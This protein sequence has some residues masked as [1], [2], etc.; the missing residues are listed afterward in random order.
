MKKVLTI[1]GFDP[2]GG[3]GIA[4][5]LKTFQ[6]RGVYGMGVATAVTAQN[7]A[8]YQ[9]TFPIAPRF[10]GLQIDSIMDDIG[11]D[12]WKTGMLVNAHII[13]TVAQKIKHYT[14]KKVIVDPVIVSKTGRRL[15]TKD[16]QSILAKYLLPLT[17]IITPNIDEAKAMTGI[18]IQNVA[19]IKKAAIMLHKMGARNVVIKGGHLNKVR[20]S[21]VTDILFDGK[22]FYEFR[23]PFI[24]THNTHGTGCVFASC[25]AAEIAKEKTVRAAVLT[26]K[27]YITE[28][29]KRSKREKIGQGNGPLLHHHGA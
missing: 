17:Y 5:D 3:A 12:V 16:G 11:A 27:R 28:M 6:T 21:P 14:I 1:A 29:L 2:C 25:L 10:V 22:R 4:A 13:R 19:D 8:I 23:S 24:N 18:A 7:T 9:G 15:L 26:A 20:S